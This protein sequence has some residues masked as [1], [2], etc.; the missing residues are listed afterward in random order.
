M[1][2]ISFSKFRNTILADAHVHLH[3]C[4]EVDQVLDCAFFNF[5]FFA[6]KLECKKDYLG[7]LFLS[8]VRSESRFN[9]LYGS[10]LFS[11]PGTGTEEI[12]SSWQFCHTH[13]AF[14]L[15]AQRGSTQQLILLAG[16]QIVTQEGL[17][18]LAL[19]TD[20]FVEDGL[21]LDETIERV[22]SNGGLP[23]L[24]WGVGKWLGKRGSLLRDFLEAASFSPIFLGDNGGRPSFWQ[25]SPYFRWAE[26]HGIG[27]LPGT[28]PLPLSSESERPGGYGFRLRGSI[29]LTE[30]GKDMKHLLLS[31]SLEIE[32]YGYLEKPLRFLKNQIALRRPK[33]FREGKAFV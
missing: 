15:L 4:F 2:L 26:M 14:S 25:K 22:I 33:S 30:P 31:R 13:E 24:P 19:I 32:T 16:R 17:E 29:S 6:D 23:V 18:V 28:D 27:I 3:P 1:S 20:R 11:Y 8:E 9:Q 7:V 5:E 12:S 21:S 10:A